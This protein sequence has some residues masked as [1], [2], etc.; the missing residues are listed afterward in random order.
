MVAMVVAGKPVL[1]PVDVKM[2]WQ[3]VFP[4]DDFA[5]SI[6]MKQRFGYYVV[7]GDFKDAKWLLAPPT[8]LAIAVPN[9]VT[10]CV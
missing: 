9:C 8:F 4:E 2:L 5:R 1:V 10:L 3:S 7:N 6:V